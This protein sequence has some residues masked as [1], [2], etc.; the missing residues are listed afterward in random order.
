MA[1]RMADSPEAPRR[2]PGG[3]RI[4]KPLKNGETPE[5]RRPRRLTR[6]HVVIRFV[7]A[8]GSFIPT[9][10]AKTLRGL[11]ASGEMFYINSL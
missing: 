2:L 4:C 6:A 11:R 10:E 5:G 1:I 3:C 7:F 8:T 9:R